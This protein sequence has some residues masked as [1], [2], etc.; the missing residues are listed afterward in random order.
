MEF[1]QTILQNFST[2][3]FSIYKKDHIDL[4]KEPLV[5]YCVP[6]GTCSHGPHCLGQGC[7][8]SDHA[9]GAY[10]K[11]RVLGAPQP[12]PTESVL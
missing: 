9:R 6:W 3:S 10:Y 12:R 11:G 1:A 4:F 2:A 5:A 8:T 7:S